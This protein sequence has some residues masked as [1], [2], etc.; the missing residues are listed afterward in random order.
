MP[1]PQKTPPRSQHK[2]PVRTR[3]AT[4]SASASAFPATVPPP[5]NCFP[6]VSSTT[7]PMKIAPATQTP[8]NIHIQ[9][10]N[11][12][13]SATN[14]NDFNITNDT[15]LIDVTHSDEPTA[16]TRLGSTSASTTNGSGRM[17]TE[18]T[19]TT[20]D[21]LATGTQPYCSAPLCQSRCVMANV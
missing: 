9:P 10:C 7:T 11:P 3:A 6:R 21:R 16:R 13:A 17:P 5:F 4:T 14:G 12:S 20:N 8:A 18:A 15:R 19:S 1:T 2:L